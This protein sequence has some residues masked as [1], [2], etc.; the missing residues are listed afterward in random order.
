MS[1][2]VKFNPPRI[3]GP[4]A[5]EHELQQGRQEREQY[6]LDAP[7][8]AARAFEALRTK[9]YHDLD[10]PYVGDRGPVAAKH[11]RAGWKAALTWA[12]EVHTRQAML[13]TLG[14][15]PA[16]GLTNDGKRDMAI[17]HMRRI[18]KAYDADKQKA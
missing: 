10:H 14:Y 11:Y 6:E 15:D 5:E 9:L 16:P 4:T 3:Q 2:A 1:D 7:E 18:I 12:E 17:S 13:E 8:R